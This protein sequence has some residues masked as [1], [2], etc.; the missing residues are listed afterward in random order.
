MAQKVINKLRDFPSIEELLQSPKLTSL[1]A[2][3]PRPMSALIVKQVVAELKTNF[4]TN[5]K[6]V[7]QQEII[8][9]IKERIFVF[10]RKE[11]SKVINATGV[12]VHTN[13]GRAPLSDSLFEAIKKTVVGYGNV[14]FDL[15]KGKR[16]Q[17]GEACE[18][19]LSLLSGAE[20][21]TVVNNC[22][23]ALFIT[24][25]SLAP[26]KN[27]VISRS[28]L[29]QIGGGFRIPDIL[30]KSGAKLS[31]VGSTNITTLTDYENNL[32]DKTGLIL[33]VHQSNFVQRGFI[34]QVSLKQLVALGA[35]NNLPVVNDLGSGVFV[36][37]KDILG[38]AEPTVQQSVRD[39]ASLTTFSGDKMLGG[40]Q[41]GLI[42]GKEKY[43]K[44]IKK[45]PLFRTMRVDKIVFSILEK[46]L[47]YYLNDQWQNEIKL[48]SILSVPEAELYKRGKKILKNLGHPE[49]ISIQAT[50]AYVGGGAL[51]EAD[52]P[53]IGILFSQQYHADR[54]LKAFR[55]LTIPIIGRIDNDCFILDLK[56]IDEYDLPY[57]IKSIKQTI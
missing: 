25:N 2:S 50:K 33:K 47:E 41:A 26:R 8:N 21:A 56:A 53:S 7:T 31:E 12:V 27:V 10:K 29:V 19:Y 16:G 55:E 43:I 52:I 42:V 38:C 23:A 18:K 34:K 54:L 40:G 39:G 49:G 36:S 22:A 4:K 17:R 20:S 24:L 5:K 51:P 44:K 6:S 30:K 35:K 3:I 9:H 15:E 48:W 45:N 28:E 46:L 11:I 14:E 57:V 1:I 13:L 37:T 32:D